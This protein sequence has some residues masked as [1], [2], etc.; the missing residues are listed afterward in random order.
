MGFFAVLNYTHIISNKILL[1][2]SWLKVKT[3]LYEN[4]MSNI[5]S[6][7]TEFNEK[8]SYSVIDRL[9]LS[10]SWRRSNLTLCVLSEWA[11]G[12]NLAVLSE[13]AAGG[14]RVED[15]Y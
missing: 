13:W 7:F 14:S 4:M 3:L 12:G 1:P 8:G 15:Y 10:F 11:A 6:F 5:K 2:I 9:K